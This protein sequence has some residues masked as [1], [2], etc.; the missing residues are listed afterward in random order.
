MVQ[1]FFTMDVAGILGFCFRDDCSGKGVLPKII[2]QATD[3][4]ALY[5]AQSVL[6]REVP[7]AC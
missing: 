7:A 6:V 5:D 3:F 2:I 1:G 4:I